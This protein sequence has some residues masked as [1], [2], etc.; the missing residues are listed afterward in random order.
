YADKL[1]QTSRRL[2][3]GNPLD[4]NQ[5]TGP[6]IN[7][8]AI[9]KILGYNELAKK[10]GAEVLLDGGRLTSG[11]LAH[12]YFLSPLIYRMQ[13]NQR[14]RSIREEVFG[15]HLALIPFKTNEEAVPIYIDT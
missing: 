9:D 12:G 4:P 7:Q 13:H 8:A 3:I 2:R 5:F 1:V 10:E 14:V 11:E 6:V 15:P